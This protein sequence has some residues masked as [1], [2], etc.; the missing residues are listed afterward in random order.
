MPTF[1]VIA[2][3]YGTTK[4]GNDVTKLVQKRLDRGN[5]EVVVSNAEMGGDP[6]PFGFKRFGIL[7]T[8]NN[9]KKPQARAGVEG[10]TIE[11]VDE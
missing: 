3:V 9:E 11:L 1:K 5:D 2:A 8:V 10:D 7:Y 4:K 6:Q